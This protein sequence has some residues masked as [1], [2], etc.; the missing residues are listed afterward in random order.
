MDTPHGM[1]NGMKHESH[2]GMWHCCHGGGMVSCFARFFLTLFILMV[3]V[4][5]AA[6]FF[7]VRGWHMGGY[8]VPGGMM[9]RWSVDKNSTRVFGIIQK[10][11]G[12]TITI[13][14][15]GNTERAVV[16]TASTIITDGDVELSIGDLKVGERI[17]VTGISD[18][19]VLTAT[20]IEVVI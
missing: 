19:E 7:G 1:Q 16:S 18:D 12:A 13:L 15:N 3:V 4:S 14:D 6:S 9:G 5:F 10:I 2:A 20:L 17:G 8:G 11:D